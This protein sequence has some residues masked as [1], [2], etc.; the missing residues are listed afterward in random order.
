MIWIAYV[1]FCVKI[2]DGNKWILTILMWSE[3]YL[4][5]VLF[6]PGCCAEWWRLSNVWQFCLYNCVGV[7]KICDLVKLTFFFGDEFSLQRNCGVCSFVGFT[8]GINFYCIFSHVFFTLNI[9][10]LSVTC[11]MYAFLGPLSTCINLCFFFVN[12]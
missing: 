2:F 3:V 7:L 9:F 8:R 6:R 12:L 5:S 11:I 1:I 4:S 10:S